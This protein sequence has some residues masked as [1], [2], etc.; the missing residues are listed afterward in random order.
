MVKDINL[1]VSLSD[2]IFQFAQF[3]VVAKVTAVMVSVHGGRPEE[4]KEW[5]EE[6]KRSVELPYLEF[7]ASEQVSYYIMK[8]YPPWAPPTSSTF[9]WHHASREKRTKRALRARV[10]RTDV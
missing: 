10:P 1:V 9:L 8:S 5:D 2:Q 4:V 3:S 6:K 7:P